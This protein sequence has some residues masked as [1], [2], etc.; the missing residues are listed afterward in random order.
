MEKCLFVVPTHGQHFEHAYKLRD[1][2]NRLQLKADLLFV[3]SDI[4]EYYG[5]ESGRAKKCFIMDGFPRGVDHRGIISIKKFQGI[6]VALQQGYEYAIVIDCETTFTRSF[7]SYEVA[8]YLSE[9]KK[10][11]STLTDHNVLI[12][13]NRRAADFFTD[14]ERE[15]LRAITKDFREYFWFNDLAFYDIAVCN[16]FFEKV[17]AGD[18]LQFYSKMSAAHFDHIIYI[19]YCLLYEEY[20]IVNLNEKINLPFEPFSQFHLGAVE[21][22]GD[23]STRDRVPREMAEKIVKEINPFWMP[24]GTDLTSDNCFMLY[25]YDR[26]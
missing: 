5:F 12:D 15:K 17:Y 25:H 23:R 7:N 20:K 11:Y 1:T 8:K 21:S 4:N 9:Q 22:I 13:I 24:Y 18:P 14:E 3:L 2:F 26:A 19:Y 16:R 10:V 6:E